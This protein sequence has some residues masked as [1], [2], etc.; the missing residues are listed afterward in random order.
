MYSVRPFACLSAW[1]QLFIPETPAGQCLQVKHLQA[2]LHS[3]SML[4]STLEE[5]GCLGVIDEVVEQIR[6]SI[7]EA[8]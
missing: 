8:N 2:V 7:S 3:G 1:E 5:K 6:D 4:G